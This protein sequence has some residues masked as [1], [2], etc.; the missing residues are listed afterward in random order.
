[1]VSLVGSFGEGSS[2]SPNSSFSVPLSSEVP[3]G[4][5]LVVAV[6]HQGG[7]VGSISGGAN[8]MWSTPLSDSSTF[9]P[10]LFIVLSYTRVTQSVSEVSVSFSEASQAVAVSVLHFSGPLF[11][12]Q[13]QVG[14]SGDGSSADLTIGPVETSHS[15][16]IL[17]LAG[18][19]LRNPGR[20]FTPTPGFSG[21]PKVVSEEAAANRAVLAEYQT[22]DSGGPFSSSGTLSSGG[23]WVG[24]IAT[25]SPSPSEPLESGLKVWDGSEWGVH[26]VK[27]WNG[28]SWIKR[29]VRV[30]DGTTWEPIL[31]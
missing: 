21:I 26:P 5:S 17:V 7:S 25:F 2:N 8:N 1:M 24:I 31:S 22:S 15:G 23:Q 10:N 28:L 27:V 6:S 18:Y 9:D 13:F 11:L 20:D 30:W 12:D 3:A 14:D 4:D 29:P 16:E 19:A